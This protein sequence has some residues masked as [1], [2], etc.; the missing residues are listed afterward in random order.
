MRA[1]E[2]TTQFRRDYKREMKGR[3]RATLENALTTV[4]RARKRHATRGK[5][6]RLS[7]F[8]RVVGV[9][10][11]PHQTRSCAHLREARCGDVAPCAAR[12]AQR[13]RMVNLTVRNRDGSMYWKPVGAGLSAEP[14][15]LQF[16]KTQD[17]TQF[18]RAS[19]IPICAAPQVGRV[20]LRVSFGQSKQSDYRFYS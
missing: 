18:D 4:L 20:L 10:G 2:R 8:R 15:R 6:S 16:D 11:L 12:L 9:S 19:P 14:R 5:I 3:H 13:A 7:A 17:T 1:I